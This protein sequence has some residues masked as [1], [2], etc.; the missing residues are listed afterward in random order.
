MTGTMRDWLPRWLSERTP[1]ERWL[2]GIGAAVLLVWV[3]VTLIWQPVQSRRHAASQQ[4]ALYDRALVA[5]Q[6]GSVPAAPAGPVDARALNAIVTEAASGFDLTI[7]RLEP[8]GERIRVTVDD[9]AFQ[10]LVLWLEAM[11]RDSALRAT[12]LDLSRRPA[13]GV[14]NA[15]MVLER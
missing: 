6:M 14:V 10:T 7:R 13:P 12:E 11:A 15:T 5:L 2:L 1:R 4:I 9:A 8:E 3:A